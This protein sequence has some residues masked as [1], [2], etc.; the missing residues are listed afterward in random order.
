MRSWGGFGTTQRAFKVGIADL[1]LIIVLRV[2]LQ[3]LSFD[4]FN[5]EQLKHGSSLTGLGLVKFVPP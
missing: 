2:R 5:P 4:L 1:E 3:L